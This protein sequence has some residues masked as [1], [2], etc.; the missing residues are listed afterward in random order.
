MGIAIVFISMLYIAI[1]IKITIYI[2]QKTNK[3][4]YAVFTILFFLLF[5]TWDVIIGKIYFNYM[6]KP[7]CGLTIYKNIQADGFLDKH[8]LIRK[9]YTCSTSFDDAKKYL[10]FGFKFYE[11]PMQDGKIFHYEKNEENEVVCK[12]LDKPKAKYIYNSQGYEMLNFILGIWQK[13]KESF[14]DIKTNKV[15]VEKIL[16]ARDGWAGRFMRH[17]SGIG[18]GERCGGDSMN[19]WFEYRLLRGKFSGN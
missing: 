3:I 7:K 9:W 14:I 16:L 18:L 4:R 11:T 12:I 2:N 8:A 10:D 6:Y 1:A 19:I 15:V 17:L 5:P 13:R